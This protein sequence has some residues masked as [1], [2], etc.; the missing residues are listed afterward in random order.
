MPLY[1]LA[2]DERHAVAFMRQGVPQPPQRV[3]TASTADAGR[4]WSPVVQTA[5][6]N[7]NAAVAVLATRAVDWWMVFNDSELDRGNL[8]LALTTEDVVE[9]VKAFME[10]REPEFKG[11]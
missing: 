9:G 5:L 2:V 1:T 4:S 3:T 7:P 6:P 11:R 10:K 8:S